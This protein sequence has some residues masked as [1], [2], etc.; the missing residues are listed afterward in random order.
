ME[1][2]YDPIKNERKI[3][4]RG[5]SFERA[6]DFKFETAVFQTQIRNGELRRVAVGYLD[7]RLHVL[8]YIPLAEGIRVISFRKANTR[9]AHEYGKEKTKATDWG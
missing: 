3:R 6:S 1:I 9:E 7:G 4:T 2:S 5:L 8:C